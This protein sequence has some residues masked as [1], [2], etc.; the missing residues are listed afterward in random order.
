MKN[1]IDWLNGRG[2][3]KPLLSHTLL[4]EKV[5]PMIGETPSTFLFVI[6]NLRFDQWKSFQPLIH[7]YFYVAEEN[8][9]YSILP[10][11]THYAR[12]ALFSGLM[13]SEIEKKYPKLW[14]NEQ[15][16]GNKNQFE[17]ELLAEYLKR[18][19]KNIK[20]GFNKILNVDFGKKVL[21]NFHQLLQNPF[22]VVIFNFIDMLSHA[23]TDIDIIRELAEDEKSY[24]SVTVSWFENSLM[25]DMLKILASKKIPVFI[26]TDHGS[27]K[28]EKPIKVVGERDMNTNLR[29]KTG[30]NMNYNE[31]EVFRIKDPNDAYLPKGSITSEFIFALGNTFFAYPNNYNYYA[32]YYKNTFQHGGISMEEILV[33]SIKLIPK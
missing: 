28:I 4:K 29:Y 32:N 33:P 14:L 23:R 6:D 2:D 25:L 7:N 18:Y 15:D 21:E 30:R 24:R 9:S 31:K 11:A 20:F 16:E 13:P 26:T 17:Q 19:G 8:I 22:N 3:E 1:Y 5:F 27:I 10:T 12:N